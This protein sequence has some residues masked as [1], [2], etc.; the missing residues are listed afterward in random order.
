MD[1]RQVL[2]RPLLTEKATIRREMENEYDFAI[3]VEEGARDPGRRKHHRP[4][5]GDVETEVVV[6]QLVAT[7]AVSAPQTG[8]TPDPGGVTP[9]GSPV[10]FRDRRAD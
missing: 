4:V 8:I 6:P 5:R 3:G 1:S 7:V 9:N 10:R 2:V